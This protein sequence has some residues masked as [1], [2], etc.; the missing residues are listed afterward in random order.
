[1][2][3]IENRALNIKSN[4]KSTPYTKEQKLKVSYIVLGRKVG[5]KL[6][7][8]P[9]GPLSARTARWGAKGKKRAS[10]NSAATVRTSQ[11]M[12]VS[13]FSHQKCN[14]FRWCFVGSIHF[15]L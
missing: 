1:M 11:G 9:S 12:H 8:S 13:F 14:Q 3:D 15:R 5:C 2:S 7:R 6:P 4:Q 10:H